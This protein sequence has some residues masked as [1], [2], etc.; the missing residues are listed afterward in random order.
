MANQ[1]VRNSTLTV[2]V[3]LDLA[4]LAVPKFWICPSPTT[5]RAHRGAGDDITW[6][7]GPTITTWF[8]HYTHTGRASYT[9]PYLHRRSNIM[10]RIRNGK[11]TMCTPSQ[12]TRPITTAGIGI[13]FTSRLPLLALHLLPPPFP[14]AFLHAPL[15]LII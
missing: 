4:D 10:R 12:R 14:F 7:S 2:K 8:Q 11:I 9:I 6:G 13:T 5:E 3:L 15:R 1:S